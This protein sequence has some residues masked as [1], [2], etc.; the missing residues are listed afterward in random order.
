MTGVGRA[1]DR[2]KWKVLSIASASV[3]ALT[4]P[5]TNACAS[6]N[7]GNVTAFVTPGVNVAR[8]VATSSPSIDS[9]TDRLSTAALP[10]FAM[11]AVTMT[12]SSLAKRVRLNVTD[13]TDTLE[14]SVAATD[15][16]VNVVPSGN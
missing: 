15:T 7:A 10:R 12:R 2:T 6:V 8:W 5:R 3:P 4:V 13:V 14:G 16:G 9:T 11:A 1:G